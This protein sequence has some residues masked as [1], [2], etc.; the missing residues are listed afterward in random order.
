MLEGLESDGKCKNSTEGIFLNNYHASYNYPI[1]KKV[2]SG[3][4]P[5]SRSSTWAR[6]FILVEVKVFGI[7]Y[8]V[9][10]RKQSAP[11]H[12]WELEGRISPQYLKKDVRRTSLKASHIDCDE[13][14]NSLCI[15]ISLQGCKKCRVARFAFN[16]HSSLGL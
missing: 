14:I 2:V 5:K 10:L 1:S 7:F 9:L 3:F 16:Q 12:S 6:T 4:F 15:N 8:S 11:L 13:A